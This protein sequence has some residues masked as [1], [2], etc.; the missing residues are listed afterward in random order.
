M[1]TP[2]EYNNSIYGQQC[3]WADRGGGE[4]VELYNPDPCNPI[5]ISGYFFGN[6]VIDSPLCNGVSFR[7]IG[8]AFVFPQGTIIP[9]NGFCVLNGEFGKNVPAGYL[10]ENGGKTVQVN[11][12]DYSDRFCIAAPGNRFWLPDV[13]GWFALYDKDGVPQDAV[14]WGQTAADI[15]ADCTP[16]NPQKAGTFMGVLPSLADIPADRKN[17]IR[18][19]MDVTKYKGLTPKRIPDGGAWSY[20]FYTEDNKGYC[21]DVC[22]NSYSSGCN[23]TASV[24]VASG[25]YTYQWNDP[26]RQTTAT[27]SGLCEGTYCCT[28][29]EKN[30]GDQEVLCVTVVRDIDDSVMDTTTVEAYIHEGDVYWFYGQKLTEAGVY[31][32][33]EQD[34]FGCDKII[35][36]QLGVKNIEITNTFSPNGDGINDFFVIKNIE[37]YPNNHLLIF[38]RWGNRLYEG[39]PYMNNWDGRNYEGGNLGKDDLPVGTYFYILDLGDGSSV[40]KGFIYLAR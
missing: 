25:S 23:G 24:A 36:L 27:A 26:A 11:L 5:D 1:T 16:C 19:E 17:R 2:N 15:C 3:V 28:M 37:L 6:S 10:V 35:A 7:G 4:W 9:P 40:K 14:Y 30:T 31:Y 33:R 13:G 22:V 12:M 21:N 8:G 38:N 29:T 39:K 20:Q 18:Y 32:H 34:E